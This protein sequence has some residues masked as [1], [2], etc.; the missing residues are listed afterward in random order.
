MHILVINPVGTDRWDE[1]DRRI[2][3]SYASPETSVDV[4]SLDS[5]P[6]SVES[7]KTYAEVVPLVVDKALDLYK[8][9]D[10]IIVNCFLDPAV[11]VLKSLLEVPIVGPCEASLALA[12]II[13]W[14]FVIVTVRGVEDAIR[15]HVR[16]LGYEHRLKSI[17][18]IDIP[19]LELDKDME[20]TKGKLLE[21]CRGAIIDG[22]NVIVLGC[23]GLAGLS[24][25]LQQELH[26]PV[27]D[28]AAAALKTLEA[29]IRLGVRRFKAQS[30]VSR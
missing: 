13:G 7:R 16:V 14:W 9:Y 30:L 24:G 12:S 1:S 17:R 21:E 20:A 22:A 2:F 4:V 25:F 27:I 11:D 26:I 23:T 10:G 5:G 6:A 19:V 3:M 8:D 28:P 15:E 18:S 29:V